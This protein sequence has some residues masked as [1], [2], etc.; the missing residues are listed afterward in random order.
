MTWRPDPGL[1]PNQI[2]KELNRQAVLFEEEC[3]HCKITASVKFETIAEQWFKEYAELNHKDTT[4][5]RERQI[6]VR[7]YPAIGYMRLN[8][9]LLFRF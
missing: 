5:Q 3:S 2:K 9:L 1:T 7:V 8:T 6:A 4:L